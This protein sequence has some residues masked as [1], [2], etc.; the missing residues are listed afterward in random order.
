[1][2]GGCDTENKKMKMRVRA[3]QNL[4]NDIRATAWQIKKISVR[5]EKIQISLG[6]RRVWS[7]SLL[8]AQW[9]AKDP[10]FLH[11][12][13]EDSSDW[14]DAQAAQSDYSLRWVHMPFC[15]FCHEAANLCIAKI[16]ISLQIGI[17]YCWPEVGTGK[18]D[19]TVW[20]CSWFDFFSWCTCHLVTWHCSVKR[21][22]LPIQ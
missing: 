1:M 7:E 14:A 12:D 9:V 6:I 22:W 15:R 4:Q 10:I 2:L 19:Q 8:C 5:P 13:S 17:V 20:L 3:W 18:S 11:V 16:Q 21:Q